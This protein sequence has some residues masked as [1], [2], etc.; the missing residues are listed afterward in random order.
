MR[1]QDE[2]VE[3]FR[4]HGLRI[5][6]QRQRIFEVLTGNE[7]HPTA[8]SVWF[9]VREQMSNVSLKTV[10][11]TL[12]ELV[13][14]GEIQQIDVGTGASRFDPN[15]S[16]HHHLV[17]RQCGKIRDLHADYSFLAPP[18][19]QDQGFHVSNAEVIFRGLCIECS[20]KA[21]EIQKENVINA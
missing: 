13:S 20:S 9:T 18:D 6:P 1:T 8:E 7:H 3:L 2:L 14:F 21:S 4:S 12:H 5:T 10:Y 11:E 17:C 19:G 15:V 16:A